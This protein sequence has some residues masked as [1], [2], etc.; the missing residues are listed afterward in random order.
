MQEHDPIFWV[1]AEVG[2]KC[3]LIQEI[4]GLADKEALKTLQIQ[5][6][7]MLLLYF[8]KRKLVIVRYPTD[9]SLAANPTLCQMKLAHVN[10]CPVLIIFNS[11]ANIF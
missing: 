6:L 4:S 10:L 11:N 1:R 3:N 8:E 9:S 5:F 2:D 7:P